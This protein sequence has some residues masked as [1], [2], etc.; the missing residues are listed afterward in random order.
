[1]IVRGHFEFKAAEEEGGE[2][3]LLMVPFIFPPGS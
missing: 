2:D 3:Y 1:M